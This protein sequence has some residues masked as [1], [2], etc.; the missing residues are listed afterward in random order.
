MGEARQI[1]EDERR[2]ALKAAGVVDM[3]NVDWAT[4]MTEVSAIETAARPLVGHYAKTGGYI[5]ELD[6]QWRSS[7]SQDPDESSVA[8]KD[9]L[10]PAEI[11]TLEFGERMM[12]LLCDHWELAP[13]ELLVFTEFGLQDEMRNAFQQSYQYQ[14]ASHELRI[15]RARLVEA[16]SCCMIVLHAIAHVKNMTF[17]DDQ[18]VRFQAAFYEG[19]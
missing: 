9:Q 8:P 11:R 18:L 4:M 12:R 13:P 1:A 10:S 17:E 19:L 16:G 15:R 6:D 5:D 7:A 14:S 2:A 3:T